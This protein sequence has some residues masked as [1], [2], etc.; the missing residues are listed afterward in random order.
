M[1]FS[2]TQFAEQWLAS[3]AASGCARSIAEARIRTIG[4]D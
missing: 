2:F 1:L 3:N 4:S